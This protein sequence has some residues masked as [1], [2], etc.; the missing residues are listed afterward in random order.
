MVDSSALLIETGSVAITV[1]K[2]QDTDSLHPVTTVNQDIVINARGDASTTEPLV[3][4][5][6]STMTTTSSR[7][8]IVIPGARKRSWDIAQTR[9]FSKPQH[10]YPLLRHGIPLAAAAAFILFSL[11][12]FTSLSD[13]NTNIPIIGDAV[14]WVRNEQTNWKLLIGDHAPIMQTGPTPTPQVSKP[15]PVILPA[16][17]YIAIA[18]QAAASAGIPPDYFVRQINEES[19]FNPYARSAAGA[20]GIA[21]FLPSTAAGLGIDPYDPVSSLYGAARY[22]ASLDK[23]YGGDYAKALAAY[24]AGPPVVTRAV[25]SGGTNW[26]AYMPAETQRYIHAIVG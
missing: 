4:A 25:N 8:P 18:R 7:Q 6:R 21:Q 3:A 9:E 13:R 11:F 2:E 5:L 22:M 14:Q 16:S 23:S 10:L 15:G 17:D 20:V 1:V 26:L 24:N 12:S 19:G